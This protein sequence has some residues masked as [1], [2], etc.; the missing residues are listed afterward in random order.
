MLA[1]GII[2]IQERISSGAVVVAGI[3]F[4]WS[5]H[6]FQPV[7]NYWLDHIYHRFKYQFPFWICF[8]DYLC[9]NNIVY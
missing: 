8:L 7:I 1:N 6:F 4:L 2:P 3:P 5:L 9:S